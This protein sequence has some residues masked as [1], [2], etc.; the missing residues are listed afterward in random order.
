MIGRWLAAPLAGL[1]LG[2]CNSSSDFRPEDVEVA[3]LERQ[4]DGHRCVGDLKKWQGA[5]V[6]KTLLSDE[7]P[8]AF[9]RRMIEFTLQRADG[10]DVSTGRK[11]MRRYED[12]E[13]KGGCSE[14]DCLYGGYVIPTNEL[15]LECEKPAP[16]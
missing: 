7:K 5:Y 16:S 3:K 14:P 8:R 9:D 13:I 15:I 1:F 2:G 6:R 4:L 12:W 10:K 11:T